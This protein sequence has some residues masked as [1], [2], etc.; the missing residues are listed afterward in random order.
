MLRLPK[1]SGSSITF[2][3]H[4][5]QRNSYNYNYQIIILAEI[6]NSNRCIK[7]QSD[8]PLLLRTLVINWM[9]SHPKYKLCTV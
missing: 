7:F 3:K 8:L 2:R 6:I 9:I 5:N 4:N 1:I